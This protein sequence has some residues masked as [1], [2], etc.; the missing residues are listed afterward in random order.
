MLSR[1]STY[2]V[3]MVFK[4]SDESYGLDYPPQEAAVAIGENKFTRQVCLLGH[5]DEGEGS[6]EVP[7]NY[8]SLMVPAIRRRLTRRHRPLPPGVTV[9]KK[10]GDGWMEMEMGEFNNEEGDDGEVSISLTEIK[11][12]RWKKGLI[13][14][15]IE[16]RAKK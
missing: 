5:E 2:A 6:E 3:Y 14:Q 4:I 15:G 8:R 12:G 1:N 7:Q 10:R 11:G 16:V 13:V 9:P